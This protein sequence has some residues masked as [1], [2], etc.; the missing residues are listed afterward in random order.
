MFASTDISI[1][2]SGTATPEEKF[3]RQVP[4]VWQNLETQPAAQKMVLHEKIRTVVGRLGNNIRFL[5]INDSYT[6]ETAEMRLAYR[7]MLRDGS[8]K[9]A[10]FTK[11]LSVA[12]LDLQVNPASQ[13]QVDK[14]AA[15]L[16]KHMLESCKGGIPGIVRSVALHGLIDGYSVCEKV[17]E[18]KKRGQYDG[19]IGL[20][21]IKAKDTR[22]LELRGDEFS[23]ITSVRDMRGGGQMW[24]PSNFIIY[25]NAPLFESPTGVSDLRAAYRAYWLIDTAWTLRAISLERYTLPF[26]VGTYLNDQSVMEETLKQ[27]RSQ[28]WAAIPEGSKVEALT[29]ASRGTTDFEAAIK[30][31]KEEVVLSIAGAVLQMLQGQVADGRGSSAVHRGTAELLQW[32]VAADTAVTLN[33]Q[34]VPELTSWNVPGADY[35]IASLGGVDDSAM[36]TSA[37]LDNTLLNQLKLPLSKEEMYKKYGRQRPLDAEDTLKPSDPFDGGGGGFGMPMGA[38]GE[39]GLPGEPPPDASTGDTALMAEQTSLARP[40]RPHNH[41]AIAALQR[42]YYRGDMPRDAVLAHAEQLHGLSTQQAVALFP[43]KRKPGARPRPQMA[44]K[45]ARISVPALPVPEPVPEIETDAPVAGT[46][47]DAA[48]AE[49]VLR[50]S[51]RRGADVLHAITQQAVRR[52]LGGPTTQ[53]TR[54]F[55]ANETA[56]L[57]EALAATTAT[58]ELLGRA[59]I[60]LRGERVVKMADGD[61][62]VD[63]P[64]G[65]LY[66]ADAPALMAPSQALLYFQRL[67]P[68]VEPP[69]FGERIGREAFTLAGVTDEV[70]LKKVQGII[71]ERLAGDA[72]ADTGPKEIEHLLEQAGIAPRNSQYAEMVFRTNM[73]DAYNEGSFAE[74]REMADTFPVWQ[75]LGI[76]DGRQSGEHAQNFGKYY[77]V[78]VSFADVRGKRIFNCRC[79]FRPISIWEWRRLQAAGARLARTA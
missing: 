31:L 66:F 20:K 55:N 53:V 22:N 37:N 63:R 69:Q 79:S 12:A 35:P 45:K 13:R 61:D 3:L 54:L 68:G 11:I 75:Y 39:T 33:D 74:L 57:A 49:V 32:M 60:K 9:A 50:Q 71:A 58:A 14:Y 17:W 19:K 65:L 59:R 28:Y 34:V 1:Y 24:H 73:M 40:A 26:L 16:V 29:L 21:A 23:N 70:L 72:P 77:P 67:T 5:P 44:E 76:A 2:T 6:D 8:V 4:L 18:V 62:G 78:N 7:V 25:S 27:A 15:D 36:L 42:A 46:Q 43:P 38:P 51:L 52:L 10:L 30:D 47:R 48:D 64:A 41:A 56:A